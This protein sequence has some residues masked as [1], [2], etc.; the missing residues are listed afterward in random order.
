VAQEAPEVITAGQAVV[1][2]IE[3]APDTKSKVS[4]GIDALESTLLPA[5]KGFVQQV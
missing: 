2:A 4:A 3:A 1:T 5:L